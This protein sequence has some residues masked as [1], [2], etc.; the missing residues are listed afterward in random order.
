MIVLH[1]SMDGKDALSVPMTSVMCKYLSMQEEGVLEHTTIMSGVNP[2]HF[3][4][5]VDH[6]AT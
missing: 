1:F 4:Q 6:C 3:S 5:L 2:I